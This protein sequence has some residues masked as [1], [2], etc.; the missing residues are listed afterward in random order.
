MRVCGPVIIV[1]SGHLSP[2]LAELAE[3]L[4]TATVLVGTGRKPVNNEHSEY[5]RKLLKNDGLNSPR[6]LN[7]LMRAACACAAPSRWCHP[8][9]RWRQCA[10]PTAGMVRK[11]GRFDISAWL[12]RSGARRHPR[13]RWERTARD[14]RRDRRRSYASPRPR[15]PVAFGEG[16]GSC[17]SLDH[18]PFSSRRC[19]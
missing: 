2:R 17:Q 12:R 14:P 18:A 19:A 1:A 10:M 13:C 15:C 9:C 5:M 7:S 6:C 3:F 4:L 11:P 16:L 8:R